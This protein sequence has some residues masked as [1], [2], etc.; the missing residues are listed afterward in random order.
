MNRF[1]PIW[2]GISA[3]AD[4]T[5]NFA[6][7][8][9][10]LVAG[11]YHDWL[12][13]VDV[14]VLAVF[15]ANGNPVNAD[16]DGIPG[17]AMVIRGPSSGSSFIYLYWHRCHHSPS[18]L[19]IRIGFAWFGQHRQT[20]ESTLIKRQSIATPSGVVLACTDCLLVAECV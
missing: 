11:L 4:Y 19:A 17:A 1:L 10:Q 5:N 3:Q 12:R 14:Q 18:N 7:A 2:S 20:K 6:L 15:D 9:N 8:E 16:N 13:R